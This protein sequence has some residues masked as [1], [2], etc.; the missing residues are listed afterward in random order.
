MLR[1]LSEKV[2]RALVFASAR[3]TTPPHS[4]SGSVVCGIPTSFFYLVVVFDEMLSA[5]RR[6]AFSFYL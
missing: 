6:D 1:S 3:V 4:K 2:S 5:G